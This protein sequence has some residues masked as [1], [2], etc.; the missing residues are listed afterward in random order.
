MS[1]FEYSKGSSNKFWESTR[2]GRRLTV[3]YG[4][5]GTEGREVVKVFATPE[6]AGRQHDA[7]VREKL[8]KGYVQVGPTGAAAD[9]GR[10]APK[11]RRAGRHVAAIP[12][13]S[14]AAQVL[15]V[16][17]SDGHTE[18]AED[19]E[20]WL[21]QLASD[22]PDDVKQ[23]VQEV[24]NRCHLRWLGDLHVPSVGN[25]WLT[26]L[27]HLRRSTVKKSAR[28][29]L[30]RPRLTLGPPSRPVW[31]VPVVEEPVR[32][33]PR[34]LEPAVRGRPAVKLVERLGA[35][36]LSHRPKYGRSLLPGL[37]P[38]DLDRLERALG[39]ELPQAFKDLYAW[40]NGQAD[41]DSLLNNFTWMYAN[42]VEREHD[43]MVELVRSEPSV[44]WSPGWIPFLS[45]GGGDFVCLD[46]DGT[47]GGAAGQVLEFWHDDDLL[48]IVHDS[49]FSWLETFVASLEAGL[50]KAKREGEFGPVKKAALEAFYRDRN[51]G[52]PRQARLKD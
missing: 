29:P 49:F 24:A 4:R 9:A 51:P 26:L 3:R 5:I 30:E 21:A 8:R 11:G 13:D 7:L 47:C 33:A 27:D 32:P 48:T 19:L 31:V 12:Q 18:A 46:L 6:E 28:S 39:Y 10:A 44:S 17:R 37:A 16:L 38:T 40:R 42:D 20:R 52:Y 50:W 34:P 23:A 15:E 41:V 2:D 35:W 43:L 25:E 22:R 1:R 36:L 45:D 14:L